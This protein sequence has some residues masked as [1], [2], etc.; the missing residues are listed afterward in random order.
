MKKMNMYHKRSA[1]DNDSELI[2]GQVPLEMLGKRIYSN[3]TV[4]ITFDVLESLRME[5]KQRSG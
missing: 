4:I 1:Y 5:S 3:L 2:V